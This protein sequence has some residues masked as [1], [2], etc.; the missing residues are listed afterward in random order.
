MVHPDHRKGLKQEGIYAFL[1]KAYRRA[2]A[3]EGPCALFYGFPTP[4]AYR[5]G[6]RVAGY[7][8]LHPVMELA[9]P[10]EHASLL[11]RF[12][13]RRIEVEEARRF[14]AEADELWK[15]FQNEETFAAVR[16]ASHLNWRYADCPDVRYRIFLARHQGRM[17]GWAVLRAGDSEPEATRLVDWLV[18]PDVSPWIEEALLQRIEDETARRGKREVRAWFPSYSEPF[19]LLQAKGYVSHKTIYPLVCRSFN[20]ELSY[21]WLKDHWYYTMGD[22]DIF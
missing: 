14:S 22:S 19:R 21:D 9:K 3:E 17:E 1:E 4:E 11:D 10:A 16:D 5:I 6:K 7:H 18:P 2:Y 20:S 13:S 8:A 15:R 12:R